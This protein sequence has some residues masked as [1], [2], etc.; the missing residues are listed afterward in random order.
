MRALVV[1][2]G[3]VGAACARTLARDGF[4][5]TLLEKQVVGGGATAAGMGHI[6]VMD[7]SEPQFALTKYSRDLWDS[8]VPEL[9]PEVEFERRGTL[10]V[11]ADEEE[12]SFVAP[13]VAWYGARGVRAEVLDAQAISGA[14][15]MLRPGLAGGFVVNEDSV[16]YAPCAAAWL[17]RGVERRVGVRISEVGDGWLRMSDGDK[18][19]ADLVVVAGGAESVALFP[20][21][22][23]KPRKGHLLITDRYPGAVHHQ[24]V[25]LGYL[26]SA[27]G[28]STESVAFNIQPRKTGQLLIGSSRQYGQTSSA[29][30]QHMVRKMLQRA[31]EYLPGLAEMSVIRGWTGFR[32]ATEDKLPVIGYLPGHTKTLLATG[33]EGLGITTSLAT[34]EIVAD[35]ALGR[36]SGIDRSPFAVERMWSE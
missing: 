18:M 36:V 32:A 1:G 8:L 21:L 28:H 17:A 25:E 15:P 4:S 10:W 24:L 27:H 13:K 3:I 11:A 34:G 2:G 23:M 31:V 5:T 12:F 35:L 19:E 14:E 9:P 7:D 16:I 26:K 30:E 20:Q 33:H 22:K 6:V 29:L